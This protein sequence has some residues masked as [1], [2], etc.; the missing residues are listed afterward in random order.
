MIFEDG[1]NVLE[2]LNDGSVHSHA[3]VGRRNLPLGSPGHLHPLGRGLSRDHG[4]L[5]EHRRHLKIGLVKAGYDHKCFDFYLNIKIGWN[6]N[7]SGFGNL[8]QSSDTIFDIDPLIHV[9]PGTL[10]HPEGGAQ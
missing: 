9:Q 2:S 1:H 4:R 6:S 8:R 10:G 3:N 5:V 7:S